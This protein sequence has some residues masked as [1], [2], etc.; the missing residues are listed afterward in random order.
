MAENADFADFVSVFHKRVGGAVRGL[1]AD[2]GTPGLEDDFVLEPAS[3]RGHGDLA[4]NMAL[5]AAS[6]LR[7][8]PR[9]L[10]E[11]LV[12][13]MRLDARLRDLARFEIAGPGFI[14]FHLHASVLVNAARDAL[15]RGSQF[16]ARTQARPQKIL[17]EFVSANPTGELH[18]G[19]A[20]YAAYGDSLKRILA[21]IGNDV[22]AEFYINDFGAQ[23]ENFGASV[24]ARY[25]QA[26]GLEVELPAD[27]YRGEYPR[28]LA[29]KIRGEIGSRLRGEIEPATTGKAVDFFKQRGCEIVLEEMKAELDRFRVRFDNWFSE[30]GLYRSGAPG[31]VVEKLKDLG[32]AFE[33]EGAL[34]LKTTGHGDDKDRVLIR[35]NGEPTY[36]ASD[37]AYHVDKL[38]RPEHYDHLVNIWGADHHGYV[39]RVKAAMQALFPDR[40]EPEIII[41]QLV[42]VI[43][44]GERKQMSKRKGTMVTLKE[45][46]AGIGVDAARFFLVDRS[47]DS[48]LDLDME[49]ARLK[50][51]ENPVYYV[52]YAHARIFSI[53]KK[54]AAENFKPVDYA[55][56]DAL[57]SQE[58]QLILSILFFPQVVQGAATGREPHRL[59]A[60][61]RDL[62]GAFHTF[63]HNCPVLKAEPQTASFRLDLCLLVRN[64][65]ARSLD[66]VGV[67]APEAM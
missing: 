21:F 59:T 24:A 66:L 36:F 38:S 32:E 44:M 35:G 54:A 23:M 2:W 19:H 52:Q 8:Q 12:E 31:K 14:N 3:K 49:K 22:A 42:N 4:T 46:L 11:R 26:L 27:G 67:S 48:T 30:A 39:S 25:A 33:K 37:I 28:Y 57:S 34:W 65:I 47:H 51:E 13:A 40:D 62:A 1:L 17:M 43:E 56:Y 9:Q 53:I 50:S 64:T 41:G 55:G 29:E 20:R 15:V 63:Y 10:A 45:L 6:H 60:Y 61:S 16:G 58:R 18:V 7:Q 5:V